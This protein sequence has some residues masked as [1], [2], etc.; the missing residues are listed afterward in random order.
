MAVHRGIKSDAQKKVGFELRPKLLQLVERK[1][2]EFATL[3]QTITHRQPDFL[4]RLAKGN[5]L[6]H[7]VGRGGHGIEKASLA[8]AAH[9]RGV[10]AQRRG[11]SG[12]QSGHP[13]RRIGGG[14]ERLLALLQVLV[15]SQG[16]TLE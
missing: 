15:V 4:V 3:L 13:L 10:E 12:Q 6:M 16:Q 1:A 14:K 9:A 5:S 11:K 7:E 2:I 8:G